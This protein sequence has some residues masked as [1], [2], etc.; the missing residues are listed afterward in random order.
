[1]PIAFCSISLI[2]L[3]IK[4]TDVDP[5]IRMQGW[6]RVKV[7]KMISHTHKYCNMLIDDDDALLKGSIDDIK[8]ADRYEE[9]DE[10][11]DDDK[12]DDAI[13]IDALNDNE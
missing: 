7:R 8:N 2:H 11:E 12:E 5:E 9:S 10:K 4:E 6:V 3:F 1:L 13:N